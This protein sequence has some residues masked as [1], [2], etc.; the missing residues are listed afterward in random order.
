MS[1]P[2]GERHNKLVN[3]DA[4]GRPLGRYAPCAPLRG[5][6]LHAR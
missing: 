6:R 1:C 3:T 5:R 2:V 4:Q